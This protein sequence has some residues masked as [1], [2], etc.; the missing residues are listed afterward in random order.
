M[1]SVLISKIIYTVKHIFRNIYSFLNKKKIEKKL[2]EKFLGLN[3][4]TINICNANCTFCGY[5]YQTRKMGT[6]DL[7]LYK[8]IITEY[9]EIGGGDL[10]LTPTVGEPLADNFIIERIKFARSFNKINKIGFYSNL[11][12]LGRFDLKDFVNSGVTD[13]V[14][15]TSGFDKDM[16]KRVYR[17]NEYERMYSNLTNLLKE[18]IRSGYPIDINVDMRTDKTLNETINF[19][20][21]KKLLQ[22]LP[23]NK[24]GCKFR[25]DDW[26]GKVKQTDLTGT[27]KIRNMMASMRFRY[28]ACFEYY[29]GPSIYWN[30]DVGICGCRD[31]DAKELIIGNVNNNKISEIWYNNKH[32]E[33]LNN[34]NKSTPEICKRCTHYDNLAVLNTKI[35]QN[36]VQQA[37]Y[38]ETAK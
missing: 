16:Y 11:I 7:D 14:I 10:G 31:V 36:K 23:A 27:M 28:S 6:M 30:G 35:W 8:K 20:D 4:E 13:L 26:A 17:S 34:F 33:I 21:Y 12:S 19:P 2:L 37:P 3:I 1:H 22:Y 32:L 15:S 24:L 38:I 18:N 9:V 29:N 25:Y 5:Q